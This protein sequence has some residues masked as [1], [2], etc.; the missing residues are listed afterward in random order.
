MGK[1]VG[2][3]WV[4]GTFGLE[5][6]WTAGPDIAKIELLARKHLKLEQ[7]AACH[8]TLYAQ[9]A[10]NKLYKIETGAGCSPMRVTL[11]VD[12]FSK[13]NSEVAIINFVHQNTN[14]PVLQI[15][16]FEDSRE[17]MLG[18]E[19]ILMEMLPGATL[20]TNWRTLS[21]D[22]KQDIVKQVAKYQAQLIH[23]R[24]Y[25]IGNLF[26]SSEA[27]C[28]LK[29]S[30]PSSVAADTNNQHLLPVL[31]QMVSMIF[32]GGDHITQDEPRGPFTKSEDWI[33]ARLTLI[34][35]DQEGILKTSED[36]DDIEEG[37]D[38]IE[39]AE[40]LL[41]LLPT[42]FPFDTI[43]PEQSILFHDNLSMHNI[44][45]GADGRITGV[46]DWECA[47]VLP[48]WRACELPQFLQGKDRT[49]EPKRDQYGAD[50]S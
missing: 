45:V 22:T 19:W 29:E 33:R 24:F 13:T 27:R 47:S 49:E 23:H 32:F 12:P 25:A 36:E 4:A 16:A 28:M 40:R 44:L 35:T 9:G 39:I 3:G 43:A 15:F 30:I 48:L 6:R 38:A 46:I 42:I 10:L 21:A 20:Q 34:I 50:N 8:V 18:F 31:G 11:P 2:L 1:Q 14:I 5:P 17:G 41:K 7:N 37:Q 26:V